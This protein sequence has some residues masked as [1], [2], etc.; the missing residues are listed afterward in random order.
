MR[1]LLQK[2]NAALAM[3]DYE[4][5]DAYCRQVL[6]QD[7]RS[8]PALMLAGETAMKDKRFE[9]AIEYF[10]AVPHSDSDTSVTAM[11]TAAEVSRA[12]GSPGDAERDYRNVLKW[13]P[14]HVHAHERLAFILDLQGRRWESTPHLFEQFRQNR[15]SFSTLIR[16]G[17]R[18]SAVPF[19]DE[20]DKI[21]QA[22][23]DPAVVKLAEAVDALAHFQ[24]AKAEPL[25][26]EAIRLK[27]NLIEA[28]ARLGRLLVDRD[29]SRMPVWQRNLPPQAESHPDVWVARGQ[30][31]QQLGQTR[32]A[33][34]CFGKAATLDPNLRIAH[35]QLS[36]LLADSEF[37]AAAVDFAERS[38]LLQQLAA[39]MN[40]LSLNRDDASAMAAASEV[41]EQLGRHWEAYGW[42]ELEVA[43]GLKADGT[44]ARER[45]DLLR[46]RLSPET[47]LTAPDSIVAT[48]LELSKWP[49]PEWPV[50]DDETPSTGPRTRKEP[51]S[52]RRLEFVDRAAETGLQ[53]TYFN[54]DDPT[55]PGTRMYE[56]SGGGVGVIDYDMDGLPDL[57]LTQGCPWPPESESTIYRDRLFH[58]TGSGHY[59]DV[60]ELAGLGDGWFSQGVAVGDL[61]NDGFP[62]LYVANI[63]RNR[64]YRNNGDGT[65]YDVTDHAGLSGQ[66]WT[67]SC[68][69]ADLDGDECPDL[70]DV[71]Y[72]KGDDLF[73]RLCQIEGRQRACA[74]SVFSAERDRIYLSQR[75]GHFREISGT[76]A[77]PL[78]PPR[79][80]LGI[81][82]A[83]F[84][85]SGRLS[86]FVANDV[87]ANAFLVNETSAKGGE[88]VLRENALLA[89]LAFDRDGRAQACMGIA[90]ADVD[91]NGLLDFF[92]TNYYEEANSLYF[93]TAPGVFVES[94]RASGL[95]DASFRQLGFGTQFLDG[96]LDGWLDLVVA[97][98]HLDDFQ[99]LDIPFRMRP[100]VF[101]N[102]GDGRFE[103]PP[104]RTTDDYFDQEL[105]GRSVAV[106]DW[107]CDG[108]P[109]FAVSHLETPAALLT[110][111]TQHI[112]HWLKIRLHGVLSSRDAIGSTVTVQCGKRVWTRQL[113]AGSGYQAS[114]ERMLLFG[115]A[116]CE[117]I[118][119]LIV[120]WPSGAMQT[121][122][123]IAPDRELTIIELGA[124]PSELT[125]SY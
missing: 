105:L 15:I 95:Y 113:T 68:L 124:T 19:P 55:V 67:T 93:Q 69:L 42:C 23:R 35:Y 77:D 46:R 39:I 71:N 63:G 61:D 112:G 62:D 97:N 119:Q 83:D 115:L 8:V 20:L 18:D 24:P 91:G 25:L 79:A 89:G 50:S 21:R 48:Q 76:E 100:Q 44:L 34:R 75:E 9:D 14:S 66:Q 70:Y 94:S 52:E 86:L 56:F 40:Q 122:D 88:L 82:A 49:L 111:E 29:L 103:E 1:E 5:A 13:R 37:A 51:D 117:H 121:F 45:L 110:N 102:Q 85:G 54:A 7:A 73:D 41:L 53:F 36:Q 43:V 125:Q 74:P 59:E 114:N 60:T 33:I 64:L 22:N 96:D 31:S 92:V 84:D 30:W 28:H 47:P 116:D 2:A 12:N 3:G 107:N 90:A 123:D 17:S 16:L 26:R 98:G 109:D 65:F 78:N 106:L 27:P 99:Y 58:N 101:S 72:L 81:V 118:D 57:Y 108:R 80:G 10:H 87:V 104:Q 4:A 32:A 6:A 120:R 38:R 11:F